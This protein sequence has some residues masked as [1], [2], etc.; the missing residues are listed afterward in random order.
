MTYTGKKIALPMA[1]VTMDGQPLNVSGNFVLS[2]MKY[3]NNKNAGQAD[4][5]PVFKAAP[6]VKDSAVKQ[7]VKNLNKGYKS[8]PLHFTITPADL[9][10]M[11]VNGTV[12]NKN[13]KWSYKLTGILDGRTVKLKFNKNELKTDFVPAA[14]YDASAS[15]I[16]IV[17]KNNYTGTAVISR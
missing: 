2:K 10:K 13:G 4:M 11:E 17:G 3:K 7:A 8:A 6:G 9:S 5:I 15:S 1:K 16:N 12:A 14:E